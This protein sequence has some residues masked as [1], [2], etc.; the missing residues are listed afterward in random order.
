MEYLFY[1]RDRPEAMDLRRQM[2]EA[3]WSFMDGYASAMI[4]RGPTLASDNDEFMTGS[5][6]LVD[7]PDAAAA[8]T[9]A[10]EEPFFKAGVF[11]EVLVH[12]WRN[13]LGRTMWD[14]TGTGRRRFMVLAHGDPDATGPAD[15]LRGQQCEYVTGGGHGNGLIAYGPL[16]ADNGEDWRGT[17]VLVESTDRA[18]AETMIRDAPYARAGL[19]TAIETHDWRFGGRP[20]T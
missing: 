10:Y 6:H 7:L 17:V 15:E 16:L 11:T 4:A 2:T 12:R 9:F 3:H 13:V 19:Y 18:A 20:A 5:L 14:F 1:G 8:D